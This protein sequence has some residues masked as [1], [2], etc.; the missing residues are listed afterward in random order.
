MVEIDSTAGVTVES[1][2]RVMMVCSARMIC[3]EVTTGSTPYHGI[4]AWVCRPFTS[5]RILS[6]LAIRPP[7]RSAITPDA[8]D[9]VT[10]RPSTAVGAGFWRAPSSIIAWAPLLRPSWPS[11]LGWNRN[12]TVP[13][14][15]A[16][17]WT[18][19]SATPIRIATWQSWP[20]RA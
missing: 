16:L 10:C 20:Q 17:Y 9:E 7:G 19:I 13:V 15:S 5:I 8:I 4:E 3:A 6:A 18:R 1:I 2:W 11:S 12:F 14:S